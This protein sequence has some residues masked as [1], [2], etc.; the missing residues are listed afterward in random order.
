MN[1]FLQRSHDALQEC[2]SRLTL[3]QLTARPPG[4]W[5]IAEILEHLS[6]AYSHTTAGARKAI[7]AQKPLSRPVGFGARLRAVVVVECGYLP[8]GVE[9]PKMVVPVGIDPATALTESTDALRDMDLA[10]AEAGGRFGLHTSV[11]NHPIIGPLSIR[12]WRKFHW[13]HTR[14]H[15]R[16]IVARSS[17]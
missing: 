17:R 5:T 15:V 2:A 9:S 4:K 3:G 8:T 14:H 13:V 12:Q 16:Q 7:A 1:R 6:R 11:M 10:L